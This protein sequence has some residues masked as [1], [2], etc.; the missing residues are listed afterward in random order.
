MLD[1]IYFDLGI[2]VGL[3][4]FLALGNS[5]F[6]RFGSELIQGSPRWTWVYG[7]VFQVVIFPLLF[8]CAW[9]VG[10]GF[11]ADYFLRPHQELKSATTQWFEKALL[12]TFGAYLA[13][14]LVVTMSPLFI[15][16]HIV[17]LCASMVCFAYPASA[18]SFLTGMVCL[19]LGSGSQSLF[20][21]KPC[22]EL[23][24][25]HLLVMSLSNIVAVFVALDPWSHRLGEVPSAVR[26]MLLFTTTCLCC[27]RQRAC[28]QNCKNLLACY[29]QQ[30]QPKQAK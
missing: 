20:M 5:L 18:R 6:V 15:L 1:N 2:F 13:R 4:L 27:M 16:H 10:T 8:L 22:R 11:H 21:L 17:C 14:D 23:E 7:G 3:T 9:G 25:L 30:Q 28:F 26:G 12:F 29:S 19:E 24:I